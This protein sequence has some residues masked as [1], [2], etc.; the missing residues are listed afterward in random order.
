MAEH[1]ILFAGPMGAGKTTA[2]ES[3]SEIEVIRTEAANSDRETADK[4][5]TTVALDYGEI[6]LGD[7]DKV[8][9]YG[10]PGQKRFDFMWNILKDRAMGMV[11]LV[12]NDAADPIGQM[13][14]FLEEFGELH[15][16]GGIVV[17]V[18]RSDVS[19]APLLGDYSAAIMA[20]LPDKL[21]PVFTVDA[22]SSDNMRVC[23]MSLILN[24]ESKALFSAADRE[25]AA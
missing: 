5:T 9:L 8:R 13:L 12:N 7:E 2:I 10:V 20:S 1:V 25:Y 17:G 19:A 22:R 18:T 3:L 6:T 24:I 23:L 16:R 11:L 21:I 14:E 4:D 15:E